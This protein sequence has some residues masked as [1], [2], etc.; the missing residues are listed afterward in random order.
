M[1]A[2]ILCGGKGERLRPLTDKTPKPLVEVN[3]IPIIVHIINHLFSHDIKDI[4]L[5]TGYMA[6]SF[7]SFFENHNCNSNI[8]IIN[9]GD[10]DIIG[11][12][13][14]TEDFISDDFLVLYGDTISNINVADLVQFHKKNK[15]ISTVSVWPLETQFGLVDIDNNNLVQGFQEKPR[16]DKWI[17]IGY[18]C[19]SK[20][21]FKV[22]HSYNSF[23]DFL[24][25]VTLREILFAYK[26]E[27]IHLTIN[28]L[29]ELDYAEKKISS[30]FDIEGDSIDR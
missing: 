14:S 17:N 8:N 22:M 24:I 16:L 18:F 10:Q 12:I 3:G 30:A 26:H 11:R 6:E 9:T 1:Q 23:E 4:I 5:T 2:I 25:G 13:L 29:Q 15:N 7:N 21:I 27:G 28:T 19:F 20:E